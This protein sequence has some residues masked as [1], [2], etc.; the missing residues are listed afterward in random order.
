MQRAVGNFVLFYIAAFVGAILGETKV[1]LE[2]I[3]F[4]L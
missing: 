4:S 2:R 1:K 3:L